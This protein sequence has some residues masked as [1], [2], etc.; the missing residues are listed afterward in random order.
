MNKLIFGMLLLCLISV[1]SSDCVSMRPGCFYGCCVEVNGDYYLEPSANVNMDCS[2][3]TCI[4][5]GFQDVCDGYNTVIAGAHDSCMD[6]CMA[7]CGYGD[8]VQSVNVPTL[9]SCGEKLGVIAGMDGTAK[10]TRAG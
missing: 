10:I 8:T 2:D 7:G 3:G 9:P 4:V 1:V 5:Y 6:D